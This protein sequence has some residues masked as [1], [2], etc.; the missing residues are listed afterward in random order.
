MGL[1]ALWAFALTMGT[2]VGPLAYLFAYNHRRKFRGVIQEWKT[3]RSVAYTI[4]YF[5]VALTL[6]TLACLFFA[7][8][9]GRMQNWELLNIPS[10]A[11]LTLG[12]TSFL[13]LAGVTLI[14]AALQ[15]FFTQLITEQGIL[16]HNRSYLRSQ[17]GTLV[18]LLP[19]SSIADYYIRS[20]YPITIYHF[21][22]LQP[23]GQYQRKVLRVPFYAT[24]RFDAVLEQKLRRA[25][26]RRHQSVSNIHKPS[27]S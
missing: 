18:D 2:L 8:Y 4:A 17:Q 12:S 9:L 3:A 16:L 19:W 1:T 7:A 15:L 11:L 10:R 13:L 6:F 5:V 25:K 27:R 24:H 20:D 23:D 22:V 21:I 14:Y 26:E